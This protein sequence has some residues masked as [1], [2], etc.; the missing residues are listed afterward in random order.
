MLKKVI[1][2]TLIAVL[3]SAC[4]NPKVAENSTETKEDT[5]KAIPTLADFD[6]EAGKYVGKE[7][8]ISGLVTHI[9]EHGGKSMHLT[10]DDGSEMSIKTKGDRFSNT[11]TG[12]KVTV[13]GTVSEFKMNEDY[14]KKWE[15]QS[16]AEHQENGDDDAF[17]N[18]SEQIKNYR[19]QMKNSGKDYISFYSL[20]YKKH[21]EK[22]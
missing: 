9:C 13:Y 5:N 4:A 17:N 10:S 6:K 20:E 11:L 18:A 12:S 3:F 1:Y 16:M 14:L 19:E 22:K 21:E 15:T 7:V 2:T 8:K